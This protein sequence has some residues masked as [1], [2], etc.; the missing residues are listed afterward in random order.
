MKP[1]FLKFD[2]PLLTAMVQAKSPARTVEL[3][4]KAYPA[5]AE[6]FGIQF[7]KFP[8]EYRNEETY[9]KLFSAAHGL[10]VYVT[11]YR[12][13][14]NKDKT[15]DQLAAELIELAKC[16]ATLCDVMTDYFAPADDECTHDPIAVK[17][18]IELINALHEAGAEVLMSAHT[19]KHTSAER[20]LEIALA[21]QER[22][23]DICKIV[24]KADTH[25]EEL[26]AMRMITM[27]KK[28]LRI[29]FLFLCGGASCSI[30]RRVGT[31]LGNCMSL[32]VFEYDDLATS[33]QPLLA[34][35]VELR[36]LI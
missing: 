16:G 15:D 36:K 35:M 26:E 32:C 22:G 3:M 29:P 33:A 34:D 6:A 7:C 2:R 28:E 12:S 13:A 31:T 18:Q 11:N 21:Q 5:G 4:D 24:I 1:T 25:E 30:L 27:L 8:A 9:K 23:A 10:P 14:E 17:K 20:V 19:R